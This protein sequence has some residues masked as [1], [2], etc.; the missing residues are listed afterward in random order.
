MKRILLITF[1]LVALFLAGCA[2]EQVEKQD[3]DVDKISIVDDE[4]AAQAGVVL[5]EESSGNLFG[6]QQVTATGNIFGA[7]G[8]E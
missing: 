2:E 1:V 4:T 7:E 6:A 3:I 5:P 8:E